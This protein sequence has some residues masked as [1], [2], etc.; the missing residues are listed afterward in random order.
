VDA[1][2]V[3][4]DP[5]ANTAIYFV[6]HAENGHRFTYLRAGSAAARMTPQ[7]LPR[8][9]I[10]GA[11]VLHVSGISQAISESACDTVFEAI[12]IARGAGVTVSYDTNL[13]LKLWPLVRARAITHAAMRDCDI[14][15]PGLDDAVHLTGRDDP[16]A[17]ADFYLGLGPTVVALTLGKAG[18]LVATPERRERIGA[19]VVDAVDA[20]AAGDTFDGAFLS[21]L[22]ACRDPFAAAR[23]ANAAAALSTL[24][25]GAVAPMP[26]RNAVLSFLAGGLPRP[27]AF[28]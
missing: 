23:Y 21:E 8:D 1:S 15:L 18:T 5:A 13:R 16:D 12:A 25:Y 10:A 2:H 6:D 17:I 3:Q 11:K 4:R 14:A 7:S 22:L 9:Y 24:G 26:R 27:N 20:T 28:G 19:R